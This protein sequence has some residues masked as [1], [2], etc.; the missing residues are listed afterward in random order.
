[1]S[2]SRLYATLDKLTGNLAAFLHL[3]KSMSWMEDD[4]DREILALC[5]RDAMGT[6]DV[7]YLNLMLRAFDGADHQ[8]L[9]HRYG[10]TIKVDLCNG[11]ATPERWGNGATADPDEAGMIASAIDECVDRC[12]SVG[13][14]TKISDIWDTSS[15]EMRRILQADYP[16]LRYHDP[17]GDGRGF[18]EWW[19]EDKRGDELQ[20][21]FDNSF[22]EDSEAETDLAQKRLLDHWDDVEGRTIAA[23][24]QQ[25]NVND[26]CNLID[27][28]AKQGEALCP[29]NS[30]GWFLRRIAELAMAEITR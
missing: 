16:S 15:D 7:G 12:D 4:S 11:I 19:T 17:E 27:A 2:A 1:M 20:T 21:A 29:D 30:A 9:E 5:C 18:I 8:Y 13:G 6:E 10:V 22:Y 14:I 23:L 28:A 24:R 26:L 3:K 25:A